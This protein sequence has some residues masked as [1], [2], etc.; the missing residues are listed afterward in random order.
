MVVDTTE[1]LEAAAITVV[2]VT[3]VMV[4]EV[5]EVMAA[6]IRVMEAIIRVMEA[7]IRVMV[8][9]IRVMAAAKDTIM[10]IMAV[11]HGMVAK[12]TVEDVAA[13]VGMV[14]NSNADNMLKVAVAATEELGYELKKFKNLFLSKLKSSSVLRYCFIVTVKATFQPCAQWCSVTFQPR[15]L[16]EKLL[17][18]HSCS[19]CE[20]HEEIKQWQSFSK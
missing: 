11:L 18:S 4:A 12:I 17:Y 6:K 3:T 1:A 2:A 15:T 16:V 5:V 13:E 8:A 14:S 10:G 19:E 20:Q 7:I 9:K